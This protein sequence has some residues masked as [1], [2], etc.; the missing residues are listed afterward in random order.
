MSPICGAFLVILGLGI[1]DLFRIS[2]LP[3]LARG[4]RVSSRAGRGGIQPGRARMQIHFPYSGT[5]IAERG[6]GLAL[7]G[8]RRAM[9]G[10]G[11]GNC[12]DYP[13]QDSNL[14]PAD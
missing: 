8:A 7:N 14:R 3:R 10:L 9:C 12:R 13:A 1:S 5:L 4:L 11:G 6:K 2:S